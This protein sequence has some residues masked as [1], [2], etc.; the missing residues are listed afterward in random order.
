MCVDA[1][2][3]PTETHLAACP[4]DAAC[5]AGLLCLPRRGLRCRWWAAEPRRSAKGSGG[6]RAEL[7]SE[8]IEPRHRRDGAEES[9]GVLGIHCVS[10]KIPGR[11]A[12]RARARARVLR[13]RDLVSPSCLRTVNSPRCWAARQLWYGKFNRG[14][15]WAVPPSPSSSPFTRHLPLGSIYED[16]TAGQG[17]V[18]DRWHVPRIRG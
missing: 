3:T 12:L 9:E 2:R 5:A 7:E 8:W 13:R 15:H 1:V 10:V 14:P 11:T 18:D 6:G 17:A 4:H 16:A